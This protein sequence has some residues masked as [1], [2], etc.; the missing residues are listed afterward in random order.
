M[1]YRKAGIAHYSRRL[2]QALAAL[3][4][5]SAG[6]EAKG[7]GVVLRVLLDRRDADV[8]WVPPNVPI[9]RTVTPAHHALESLALPVELARLPLDVLHSPDFVTCAGRF[10]KVITIHDLYFVE[11][12]EVMSADGARYYSRARWSARQADRIIAV[13]EFTRQEI[14]R[15]IPEATGRAA[16]VHEAAD[17]SGTEIG[18]LGRK[19]IRNAHSLS[20]FARPDARFVLFVG[21]LE[22]RKNLV[23]LLRALARMPEEVR[24]IAVGAEGWGDAEPGRVAGQLGVSDRVTLAGRVSDGELDTLYRAAHAFAMPSLSE[25]FGLPVLEAM[26]RGTP[27][28]CSRAGSL[29]EIAGDAALMHAPTDDAE[30][31]AHLGALWS[32]DALRAAYSRR[33]IER[34]GQFTWRKA[35]AETLRVYRAAID[36]PGSKT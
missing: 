23:T 30:L 8:A 3:S 35:A 28:V 36:E 10:R 21:T 13:S 14:A 12:P 32:D 15:L 16:V 24:L 31:A 34:A 18:Q 5:A 20:R 7:E 1:F 25:G 4:F 11:H 6:S 22:P 2:V 19:G 33:G 9:I 17:E 27:V 29:P 26:T